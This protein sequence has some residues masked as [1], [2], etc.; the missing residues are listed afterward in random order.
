MPAVPVRPV[1]GDTAAMTPRLLMITAHDY[2]LPFLIFERSMRTVRA[3]EPGESRVGGGAAL[4]RPIVV[5]R[6]VTR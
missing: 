5:G 1:A 4:Q 6:V 2:A 3:V